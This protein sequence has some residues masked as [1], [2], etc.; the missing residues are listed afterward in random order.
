M[1]DTSSAQAVDGKT[2]T[3][4]TL[5]NVVGDI[6]LVK[7]VNHTIQ[8][9]ASTTAATAGA[10]LSIKSANGNGAAAG[11]VSV[12]TGTGTAGGVTKLGTDNAESTSIGR[13]GKASLVNG[14]ME[15]TE[16]FRADAAAS[17]AGV[18]GFGTAESLSGAG[19]VGV[20]KTVTNLTATGV[21]DA[22]TLANSTENTQ[23]K[24]IVALSGYGANTSVLIP[25]NRNGY[26]SITFTAAG[27]AVLLLFSGGKWT[28][29]SNNGATVA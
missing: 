3:G 15:V 21:G 20:T 29:I 24:Y 26:A 25:T 4:A 8:P 12:D 1:V 19:A 5:T 6:T 7:E 9:A 2:L 10:N 27:Q 17:L 23:M 22:L 13:A 18:V 11:D 16:G 28:I 14:S